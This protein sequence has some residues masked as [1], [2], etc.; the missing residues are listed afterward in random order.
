M[1][2]GG[3]GPSPPPLATAP[4]THSSIARAPSLPPPSLTTYVHAAA[5]MRRVFVALAA[6]SASA[7][8]ALRG[9][10]LASIPTPGVATPDAALPLPSPLLARFLQEA[11]A[12]ERAKGDAFLPRLLQAAAAAPAG[13]GAA[14]AAPAAGGGGAAATPRPRNSTALKPSGAPSKANVTEP[15]VMG[16]PPHILGNIQVAILCAAIGA[17]IVVGALCG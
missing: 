4:T 16:D 17:G 11:A 12:A 13:G 15:F 6:A 3:E 1:G 9:A 7:D 14:A 5:M 8:Q 2:R 10:P